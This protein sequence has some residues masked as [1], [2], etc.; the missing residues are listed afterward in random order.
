MRPKR[1]VDLLLHLHLVD[2]R[3]AVLDRVLD[4]DDLVLG[5]VDL[6]QRGVQRG[7]L[8]A[9]GGPGH[10]D[11]PAGPVDDIA[12]ARQNPGRHAQAVQGQQPGALIEQAHHH[13]LAVLHRHGRDAHVDLGVAHLDVEAAVLR[14]ALLGDVQPGHQLQAQHQRRG[15][16]GIGLGLH[17]QHA[18]DAEA[19]DQPGL[20]RLDV[21]VGGAHAHRVLEHASAAGARPARPRPQ[22]EIPSAAKST[23]AFAQ[24]LAQL[25]GQAGDLLGAAVDAVDGLQQERSR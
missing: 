8:A 21:D 20:L 7:G 2:P 23:P 19:D 15:D 6:L 1:Q 25:L 11:H 17:V 24:L 22:S 14:Q 16:L 13:R 12:H 4:G 3:Q 18:V 9:A 5:R 10:Q